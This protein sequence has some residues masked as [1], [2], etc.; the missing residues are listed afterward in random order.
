MEVPGSNP[1]EPN[2]AEKRKIDLK[3]GTLILKPRDFW[4]RRGTLF[5]TKLKEGKLVLKKEGGKLAFIHEIYNT[6]TR[7]EVDVSDLEFEE[8]EEIAITWSVFSRKC[9]LYVNGEKVIEAELNYSENLS[10]IA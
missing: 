3:E 1:G 9:C 6:P 7:I 4:R 8:V 5:N 10:Y 2:M